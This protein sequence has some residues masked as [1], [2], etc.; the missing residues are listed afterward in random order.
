MG[1]RTPFLP[2]EKPYTE[3]REYLLFYKLKEFTEQD[4]SLASR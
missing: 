2:R 3:H 1:I 4:P